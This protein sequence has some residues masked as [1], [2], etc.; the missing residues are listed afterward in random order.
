MVSSATITTGGGNLTVSGTGGGGGTGDSNHGIFV[1]S[2]GTIAGTGASVVIVNGRGGNAAGT[3]A[4]NCGIQVFQ[5]NSK[6]SSETGTLTVNGTG[7]GGTGSTNNR[8]VWILSSGTITTGGGN[9]TVNGTGGGSGT[10]TQNHGIRIESGGSIAGTASSVVS[11]TGRGGNSAGSGS[12]NYGIVVYQTN[13]KISSATGTLSV[14]GIGGGGDGSGLNRGIWVH[15]SASI[16]TGGGT[17][18]ISGTGGGGSGGSG[19]LGIYLSGSATVTTSGNL[20]VNGTGGGSGTAT[21]NQGIHI[22]S[23]G[24]IAGTASSVVTVTGTGGN[25]AGSGD[26]NTG[27][28]VTDTNSKI[29]SATGTLNVTGSGGG[30]ANSGSNYGVNVVSSATITTG[31]GNLTVTGSGGGGS[32]GSSNYGVYVSS[33]GTITTSGNIT[34]Q[35]TGGGSGTGGVNQGIRIDN[36]G[37]ILGTGSSNV[38]VTGKGGNVAGSGSDNYGIVVYQ[39]NSKISS[40]TGTLSVTGIGGGGDGSGL[41]RG[42]WALSSASITTG[43]GALTISGTGGGG[44]DGS[45]NLGTY[46][47]GAATF[48]TSGSLT[49]TGSGGGSGTGSSN[50]G[51]YIESASIAGT[52]TSVVSVTGTG[53]NSA[54]SGD[55]NQGVVVSGGDSKITSGTA[56]LTVTGAGGGGANSNKNHGVY[57]VNSG[58]IT[59]GGGNLTVNG[60]GGGGNSGGSGQFNVGV[61]LEAAGS[62]KGTGAAVTTV[63]GMGGNRAGTGYYD[64][65]ILVTGA[66]SKI[67]SETGALNVTG[68]G[69][70]S[71]ESGASWGSEYEYCVSVV[72]TGTISSTSGNVTVTGTGGGAGRGYYNYGIDAENSRGNFNGIWTGGAGILTLNG[73]GGD[74]T[75]SAYRDYGIY[76]YGV[77]VF[78]GTGN[79]I[80]NAVGG[81]ATGLYDSS[82]NYAIASS[83]NTL[84]TA[85]GNMTINTTVGPNTTTSMDLFYTTF[86][87]S[88]NGGNISFVLDRPWSMS[89]TAINTPAANSVT[90]VPC[91]AGTPMLV[92]GTGTG[93]VIPSGS[94]ASISAGTIILGNATTGSISLNNAF[95]TGS[96]VKFITAG[97]A[98]VTP[99]VNGPSADLFNNG[100]MSFAAGIP[101]NIAVN[102]ATADPDTGYTQLS[103][104]S[105]T[106][107]LSGLSLNLTGAYTPAAG[108]VFTIVSALSVTG[109]FNNLADGALLTF[110]ARTLQIHYTTTAVTLSDVAPAITAQPANTTVGAGSTAT[111]TAAATGYPIPSVLWQKSTDGGNN[112]TNITGNPSA[113]TTTYSFTTTKAD[114][115]SQFRAYFLNTYGN[116]TTNAATLTVQYAPTIS[117]QPTSTSVNA[118]STVN[119]TAVASANPAATVQW[120]KSTDGGLN[121]TNITGNPS[122]ITTTLSFTAAKADNGTLYQAVFT[123]ALGTQDTQ[124]VKLTVNY[125]PTVTNQPVSQSVIEGATVEFIAAVDA[126]PT[127]NVQWQVSTNGGTNWT[128]ITGNPTA[129]TIHYSFTATLGDN[130]KQY[131]AVFSNGIGS[132]TTTSAATLTVTPASYTVTTQPADSTVNAGQTASFTAQTNGSP[133]PS[134]QWQKSTD[135]GQNWANI[136]DNPTATTTTY[137]FATAKTDNGTQYKAVFTGTLG[138]AVSQSALL[139]VNYAPSV[140]TQPQNEAVENG[141]TATFIAKADANPVATVQWQVS[142]N[143]GQTWTNV[144]KGTGA[145]SNTYSF[146]AVKSDK[147]NQYQAI[148]SNTLGT[149]TTSAATLDVE[150]PPVIT[151]QPINQT[152]NA[153]DTVSFNAVASSNPEA[154]IQ[155][156]VSTNG[157]QTWANVSKG[158]GVTSNTYSFTATSADNGT[159]YQAVFTNAF[160]IQDTQDATLTVNFAPVVTT[161]PSSTT[162]N[163]GATATFIAAATSNPAYTGVQ[164]QSNSGGGWADITGATSASYTT[165]TLA[166]TDNGTLYRAV[167]SNSVGSTNSNAATLTVNYAPIISTPPSNTTVTAGQTA[168]FT[169]AATSNPAYTS[170][171]WQVLGTGSGAVWTNVFTGTGGTTTSYT[172]GTLSGSDS[173]NQY[174]AVFTNSVGPT[175]TNAATL[176]VNLISTTTTLA[177]SANPSALGDSVT[178]T[179]T[180]TSGATGTVTFKDGSTTLGTGPINSGQATYSTSSLTAG[181]HSITAVYE[182]DS[183]YATSTSNAVAQVVAA[184]PVVT[185][186]PS[187]QTVNAGAT[188]TFTATATGNP[189]PSVQWQVSTNGGSTW[190]VIA[191]VTTTSYTTPAST[192]ANDGTQYRAV[193]SNSVGSAASTAATLHVNQAPSITGQPVNV[194]ANSGSTATFSA[195]A[196]GFPVPTVQWQKYTSGVWA[197]ITG[198]TST[199]YTTPTLTSGDNGTQYRAVFHNGI[200]NDAT[201]SAAMLTIASVAQV[202]NTAVGW[203]SQIANLIDKGDGR[204]LPAGRNNDMPWLNVNKVTIT[205]ST[206]VSLTKNNVTAK[207]VSGGTYA[208]DT[209]NSTDGGTTWTITLA[210][211]GIATPDRVTVTIN[212]ANVATFSKRLDVLPGDVNDDGIVNSLDTL[213]VRNYINNPGSVTILWSF[214]DINGDGTVNAND[215]SLVT[216]RNGKKLPA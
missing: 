214:L 194:T 204:L 59:T 57:V 216:A 15:S 45:G 4:A 12:D 56:S 53:G 1:S 113:T 199:S 205:L 130:A 37:S 148:F 166:S 89:S 120:Q 206:P 136:T 99:K 145:T 135:G 52:S 68:T 85:G 48:T 165:S 88:A 127:A 209:V 66:N 126:N 106:I 39:T 196:T 29:S 27:I 208:I 169:A 75:G 104:P 42:I 105:G 123:N 13:S 43:G 140:T 134:V 20:T 67:S 77:N 202:T 31:G 215:T 3:G 162:A 109:A 163:A 168:S 47:G 137:S 114:N 128:D 5:T 186:N 6:I 177:S 158:T 78:S 161:Q 181:S 41:N 116:A 7:G 94:L 132:N 141:G 23:G 35:G 207:G 160:G 14:T 156:Q 118:G 38:L 121:W 71:Y 26:G 54:G 64:S 62:I 178:F 2:G 58:T 167:F 16:S 146:T 175:N 183:Y 176:M 198:A 203:G 195:T 179:V 11:V 159:V 187:S 112:W 63:S 210:G 10:A 28:V 193:F 149:I 197:N 30:G 188:A 153:G 191:G 172:T 212:N 192:A 111:F 157:G 72:D 171:Q 46:L 51:I 155:W 115:G 110:K 150:F 124:D 107:N 147:G 133:A 96:N 91:A 174:R 49:V 139:T 92:G 61:Q 201:T 40:A 76:L 151:T 81:G 143:G 152:V 102:G 180:V 87:T 211:N 80:I 82:Y 33:S 36:A 86:T 170:V 213:L 185:S 101:L 44:L 95:S 100:T 24:S 129:T 22:E 17:L 18:T 55:G 32:G 117:T 97:S 119:F 142:T 84:S 90:V 200:G 189:A 154:T 25:S 184:A 182:G 70:G 65:G 93:L 131:H 190:T 138:S 79:L 8:G 98:G 108:D 60:T 21:Q 74:L 50:Q 83:F 19:N 69:G 125:A 34:V 122:A 73:Q 144:T 164:W 9:L 173:G 103:S